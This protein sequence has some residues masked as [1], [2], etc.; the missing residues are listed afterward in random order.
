[1]RLASGNKCVFFFHLGWERR[2]HKVGQVLQ[3]EKQLKKKE[4]KRNRW[5]GI[6]SR[7]DGK[8]KEKHNMN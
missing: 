4:R 3:D 7:S 5:S 6:E 1:M 8:F 2:D